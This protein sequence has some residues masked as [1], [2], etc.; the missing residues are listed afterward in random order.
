MGCWFGRWN[1]LVGASPERSLELS[2]N[3][4]WLA[5]VPTCSWPKLP[6]LPVVVVEPTGTLS[7]PAERR[8][9]GE[10]GA[11]GW[12][13][14]CCRRSYAVAVDRCRS[15][16]VRWERNVGKLRIHLTVKHHFLWALHWCRSMDWEGY[17]SLCLH[18]CRSIFHDSLKNFDQQNWRVYIYLRL[19][20]GS[21]RIRRG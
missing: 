12:A 14:T 7:P 21:G 13:L 4:C 1:K 5:F 9:W 11:G 2:G 8:G 20:C 19:F 15:M 10:R 16:N 18:W 6:L 3:W 17:I